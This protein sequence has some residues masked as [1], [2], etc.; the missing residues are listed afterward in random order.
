MKAETGTRRQPLRSIKRHLAGSGRAIGFMLVA[1]GV[2]V[3]WKKLSDPYGLF[4]PPGDGALVAIG[5]IGGG[6]LLLR[7]D[8]TVKPGFVGKETV[9]EPRARSPLTLFT[10]AAAFVG[11]G[12]GII[13]GNVSVIS[14]SIGQ[15]TALF[16]VVLGGG[17][18]V[19][20]W[21]G[22]AR[23]LIPIGILV[24]PAAL[25]TSYIDMPPRGHV[26][27]NYVAPRSTGAIAARYNLLFGNMTLDLTRLR[28]VTGSTF[29]NIN[30]AAG[31]VTVYVPE[32]L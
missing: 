9:K 1:L 2:V 17:L 19:G 22:R 4:D 26:G 23:W 25:V 24:V 28:D 16:L 8:P 14:L 29:T 20:A 10:L 12:I 13:L 5:L 27:S 11:L 7:D 15:L 21:W 30:V 3:V 6:I 31:N 32:R 18:V